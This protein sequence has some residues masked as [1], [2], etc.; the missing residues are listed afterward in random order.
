M[1][2][3]A[4]TPR[5]SRIEKDENASRSSAG[6]KPSSTPITSRPTN[7]QPSYV[8]SRNLRNCSCQLKL[9]IKFCKSWHR[10]RVQDQSTTLISYT[11]GIQL[12]HLQLI[13]VTAIISR[14]IPPLTGR[15]GSQKPT[16][17][18]TD[19]TAAKW[20]KGQAVLKAKVCKSGRT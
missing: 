17:N 7:H 14:P 2:K 6:E 18:R 9:P 3:R 5:S 10:S 12:A 19:L 20:F 15:E 1:G 8:H 13:L 11:A 16:Q 4:T